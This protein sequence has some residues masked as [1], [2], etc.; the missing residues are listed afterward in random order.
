VRYCEIGIFKIIKMR[1]SML[2]LCFIVVERIEYISLHWV[3]HCNICVKFEFNRLL[4][5]KTILYVSICKLTILL[6]IFYNIPIYIA[7]RLIYF[8]INSTINFINFC[9]IF[10]SILS[11]FI[12]IIINVNKL[13][14]AIF[15][16]D[17]IISSYY[18]IR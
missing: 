12:F 8:T 7:N 15:K 13:N 18:S 17:K 5:I 16:L 11:M 3:S 10:C 6:S 2:L 4:H 14:N 9:K 1:E